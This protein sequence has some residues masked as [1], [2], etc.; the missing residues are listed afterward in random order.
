M[1]SGLYHVSDSAPHLPWPCLF[2][3]QLTVG[4][5]ALLIRLLND[6][7]VERYDLSHIRQFDTGAAP[8]SEQ[9]VAKLS[10]RFP[11][12]A[13][14]QSWGMTESTSALT[15][16]PPG[17]DIWENAM[18]VGKLVPGTEVKVVDPGTGRVLGVDEPGEVSCDAL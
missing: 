14:R 12:V 13:I 6:P 4:S 2:D 8:L 3:H 5:A 15:T 11:D 17:L 18:K 16:T 7:I 10:R 1:S 9:V